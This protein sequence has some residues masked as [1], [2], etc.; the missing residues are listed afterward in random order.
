MK[1]VI[2][3]HVTALLC[4]KTHLLLKS[5]PPSITPL[6]VCTVCVLKLSCFPSAFIFQELLF[7]DILH[8]PESCGV[9]SCLLCTTHWPSCPLWGCTILIITVITPSFEVHVPGRRLMYSGGHISIILSSPNQSNWISRAAKI[10]T[11]DGFLFDWCVR[12]G[13]RLNVQYRPLIDSIIMQAA[14]QTK[15]AV[16]LWVPLSHAKRRSHLSAAHFTPSTTIPQ[17]LQA[18]KRLCA[19]IKKSLCVHW[20]LPGK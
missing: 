9:K 4:S 13:W 1:C 14:A 2:S 17:L 6:F 16:R 12:W 15:N 3:K 18:L 19:P 10:C 11:N 7:S 8:G 20:E 5:R